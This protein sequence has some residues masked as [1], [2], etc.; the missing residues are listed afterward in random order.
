[1]LPDGTLILMEACLFL[2]F[3]LNW[4]NVP[5][6]NKGTH[7][8]TTTTW[9]LCVCLRTAHQ[10]TLNSYHHH[11]KFSHEMSTSQ[12]ESSPFYCLQPDE[13]NDS[14]P[15]VTSINSLLDIVNQATAEFG[16]ADH[17]RIKR[18]VFN[19]QDLPPHNRFKLLLAAAIPLFGQVFTNHE[20]DAFVP[21]YRSHAISKCLN[22]LS[23]LCWVVGL[24][25]PFAS[26]SPSPA[27]PSPL[28]PPGLAAT[29]VD[30][31]GL[32]EDTP[33]DS[34]PVTPTAPV[35]PALP[36]VPASPS[37]LPTRSTAPPTRP[38]TPKAKPKPKLT[39]ATTPTP[40]SAPTA[41]RDGP[42]PSAEVGKTGTS[43]GK[44]TAQAQPQG[45]G[46]QAQA[47]AKTPP[48]TYTTAEAAPRLPARASLVISLS[49]TTAS[50]HLQAQ[51]SMAPVSLVTVCNEALGN[52]PRHANVQL[53]AAR[54]MPKGNLVVVGGPATSLAQLKDATS[55]VTNTIQSTLPEP[56][57]SLAS[58]ANVKWS[59]LLINGVLTG[60]SDRSQAYTPAECQR[61]LALDNPNF[62]H[63][64]ITQLPSWV[65]PPS[66]YSP[67]AYS[68]LIVTFEDPDGSLASGIVAAKWLYLFS[69]QAT[70][71]RWKQKPR[72]QW[73][74]AFK[75]QPAPPGAAAAAPVDSNATASSSK[76]QLTPA[77]RSS[78]KQERQVSRALSV[79]SQISVE[80][81]LGEE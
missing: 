47:P 53:S 18:F 4:F 56:T 68:S 59:K 78:R 75:G 6:I 70:V 80:T 81:R 25:G 52:A 76:K 33:M 16:T 55:L 12:R 73:K 38:P 60:V 3:F 61:A 11:L 74:N 27:P 41:K 8:L 32:R 58:R 24:D 49:H 79:L 57:T 51:A 66:S 35:A 37:P 10:R 44:Q 77:P 23:A 46:A 9:L 36:P 19:N 30:L 21:D 67:G 15:T 17:I 45:K 48:T 63:L 62:G 14:V 7:V 43:K 69:A 64:T 20:M 31:W 65:R 28:L 72:M 13:N 26:P 1:M 54:W 29:V 39:P 34:D 40:P 5:P 2:F 22:A 50:V 42:A 71:K